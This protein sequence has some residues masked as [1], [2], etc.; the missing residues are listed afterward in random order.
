MTSHEYAK[1]LHEIAEFLLDRP[2]FKTPS[3][4][5][6]IY[7]WFYNKEEFLGA[8]KSLGSG[9]KTYKDNELEYLTKCGRVQLS[10]PRHLICRKI[11]EAEY[12]CVPLLSQEEEATLGN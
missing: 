2:E 4:I 10:I 8:V 1:R 3:V 11:K 12:E 7:M 9:I 6:H 5:K